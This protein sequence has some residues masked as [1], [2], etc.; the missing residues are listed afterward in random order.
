MEGGGEVDES[1][2]IQFV[3]IAKCLAGGCTRC[4]HRG[5]S[6]ILGK[7]AEIRAER[8]DYLIPLPFPPLFFLSFFLNRFVLEANFDFSLASVYRVLIGSIVESRPGMRYIRLILR[9]FSLKI[10]SNYFSRAV[11]F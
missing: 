4:K 5:V 7:V 11:K 9:K 8:L 3:R 1:K 2:E 6:I 10:L